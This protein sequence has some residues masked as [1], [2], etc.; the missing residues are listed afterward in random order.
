[1]CGMA[2]LRL[3]VLRHLFS[4]DDSCVNSITLKMLLQTIPYQA[5]CA[6]RLLPQWVLLMA[7]FAKNT[8]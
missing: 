5:S 2:C 3:V 6:A 8:N 4:L 7:L 1:M